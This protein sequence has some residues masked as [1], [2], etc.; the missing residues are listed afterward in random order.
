MTDRIPELILAL[1]LVL[2]VGA[3][4]PSAD[5]ASRETAG[6]LPAL[7][8]CEPATA[9]LRVD[10]RNKHVGLTGTAEVCALFLPLGTM[11]RLNGPWTVSSTS[12][13]TK[14]FA[15][16]TGVLDIRILWAQSDVYATS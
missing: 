2:I 3:C 8:Q 1:I 7:G 15:D 9:T 14:R 4:S 5:N 6:T 12:A 13:P 16:L 10:E 11:Y